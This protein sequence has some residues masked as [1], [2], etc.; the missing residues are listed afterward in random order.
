MI[1][2]KPTGT[3]SGDVMVFYYF[4]RNA[5]SQISSGPAGWTQDVSLSQTFDGTSHFADLFHLVAGGSEPSSY[6][7]NLQG[8]SGEKDGVIL[9]YRPAHG[10]QLDV[11]GFDNPITMSSASHL[12]SSMTTNFANSALV[13][14]WMLN[15]AGTNTLSLGFS[16]PAG[17]TER[18]KD[19][20]STLARP[21]VGLAIY[22]EARPTAGA[23]GSRTLFTVDSDVGSLGI[24]CAI[25]AA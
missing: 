22:D 14:A 3:V 25:R 8:G 21:D 1:V 23:T 6:T 9:T 16:A 2:S 7:W 4:G 19:N 24:R 15:R 5:P 12:Q 13:Y 17:M 18:Y 11:T 20:Y 10:T